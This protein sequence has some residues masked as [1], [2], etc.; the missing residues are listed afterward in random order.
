MKLS[1]TISG[2]RENEKVTQQLK[3]L[4]FQSPEPTLKNKIKSGHGNTYL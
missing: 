3:G 4:P 2:N 1:K